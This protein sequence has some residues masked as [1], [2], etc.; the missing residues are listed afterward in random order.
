MLD[1][2]AELTISGGGSFIKLDASGVTLSGPGIKINSGGS[3]GRG[4]N[5]DLSSAELPAG[6]SMDGGAAVPPAKLAE[7]GQRRNAEAES[8][9]PRELEKP[10]RELIVDVIGGTS[11]GEDVLVINSVAGESE[12]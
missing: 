12:Q 5:V 6:L 8:V 10:R 11:A 1:A 9:P 4:S 2:G 7:V 3:P